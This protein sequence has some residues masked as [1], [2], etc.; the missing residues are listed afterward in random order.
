M[1]LY[2][3]FHIHSC[4]SPCGDELMTPNNIVNM[5]KIKGLDAIAITDHNCACNLPAVQTVAEQAGLLFLPGIEVQ[6]KEEVHLLCYFGNMQ[7]ALECGD[8][9]YQSLPDINNNTEIFG[10]QLILDAADNVIGSANKLLLQSVAFSIEEIF[11][12]VVGH[13][14]AVVPAH[15]NKP[16]NS[17]LALLGF[18]PAVPHFTM[19]EVARKY[20]M[21]TLKGYRMVHSSDAHSLEDIAEREEMLL[22]K[23]T[24]LRGIIQA[25]NAEF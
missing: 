14:G 6:S 3:D 24:T 12:L 22:V 10:E 8:I 11:A 4:L 19:L 18:I 13:H 21:P 16:S 25:F 17:L 20:P 5:A 1:K 9:F 15:I 2:Y 7:D 23:D